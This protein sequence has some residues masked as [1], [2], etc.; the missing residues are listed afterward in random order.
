MKSNPGY[1]ISSN[2]AP[3]NC[4]MAIPSEIAIVS[5]PNWRQRWPSRPSG[6][7][8][9]WRPRRIR[10]ARHRPWRRPRPRRRR[11][12]RPTRERRRDSP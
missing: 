8:D 12:R 9:S 5:A 10:A 4:A 7:S 11:P 2:M 1:A 6:Y 3:I